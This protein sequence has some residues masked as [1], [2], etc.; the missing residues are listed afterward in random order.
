MEQFKVGDIVKPNI[1]EIKKEN[2]SLD[3]YNTLANIML[4]GEIIDATVG[5]H[6]VQIRI[7]KSRENLE[8]YIGGIFALC[9]KDFNLISHV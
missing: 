6:W 7:T 3:T 2:A 9:V 5:G 1:K 4:E 8:R